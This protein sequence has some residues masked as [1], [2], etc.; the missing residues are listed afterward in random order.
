MYPHA[1]PDNQVNIAALHLDRLRLERQSSAI[2]AFASH[3]HPVHTVC[4]V[5]AAV[6]QVTEEEEEQVEEG[7]EEEQE[8][9]EQEQKEQE[10]QEQ[11]QEEE[12]EEDGEDGE[13]NGRRIFSLISQEI[14]AKFYLSK[15]GASC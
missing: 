8:Q 4:E 6:K 3:H 14:K 13:E 1:T 11:E 12:E 15:A 7:Q 9:K 5:V 10:E 2:T